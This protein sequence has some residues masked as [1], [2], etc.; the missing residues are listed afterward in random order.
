[1]QSIAIKTENKEQR[2]EV[3]DFFKWKGY[4]IQNA[5]IFDFELCVFVIHSMR[6]MIIRTNQAADENNIDNGYQV[7]TFKEF[8]AG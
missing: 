5:P 2:Q 8:H 3:I 1:M 6:S 7:I 4:S